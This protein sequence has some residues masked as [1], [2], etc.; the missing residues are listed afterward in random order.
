MQNKRIAITGGVG[1]GKSTLLAAFR[2]LGYPTASCDEVVAALWQEQ[3]FLEGLK[4]IFHE[5]ETI[6]KGTVSK[7]VFRDPILRERLNDYTHPKVME[8]VLKP[9]Q[10]LYF[11]E[12]PLLFE[13]GLQGLFDGVVAVRRSKESRI[14]SLVSSRN[15]TKQEAISRMKTQ[16]DP[17]RL[18][19]MNC[20]VVEND[21]DVE[22]LQAAAARLVEIFLA[23][24]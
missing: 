8:R 6:D 24:K 12:V 1:S 21:G 13:C 10:G 2:T 4:D 14:E 5:L 17:A 3:D 23:A 19:E 18:D 7:A 16:F 15:W 9:V 20:F 22:K 11:V